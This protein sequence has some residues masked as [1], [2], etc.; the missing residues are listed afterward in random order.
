MPARQIRSKRGMKKA[1]KVKK[2]VMRI[3]KQRK[4][5]DKI[6]TRRNAAWRLSRPE[7][8]AKLTYLIHNASRSWR[9]MV[10]Q[11]KRLKKGLPLGAGRRGPS[12]KVRGPRPANY[13]ELLNLI[14][15]ACQTTPVSSGQMVI[16]LPHDPTP[17]YVWVR[18]CV[19]AVRRHGQTNWFVISVP[20]NDKYHVIDGTNVFVDP[21]PEVKIHLTPRPQLLDRRT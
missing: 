10:R 20:G 14:P 19:H 15:E 16:F 5:S 9:K 6:N 8:A 13:S 17:I 4:I 12:P 3:K 18:G 1:N 2:P 11:H 21:G 7:E